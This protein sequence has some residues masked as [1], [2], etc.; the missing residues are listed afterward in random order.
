[1][2]LKFIWSVLYNAEY[3]YTLRVD[4]KSDVYSF[5]VVLLELLTGR[6][7]VGDFG[8]GVDIVQWARRVTNCR[9]EEVVCIVDP[10]LTMVP[11]DEAMHFFCDSVFHIHYLDPAISLCRTY[12]FKGD[13][14]SPK[15]SN[16][17]SCA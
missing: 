4:E 11:N 2:Y 10:R 3:A 7:P 16:Q 6:R 12:P 13:K 1:M 15:L 9:K 8:E 5:G 14:N 17:R